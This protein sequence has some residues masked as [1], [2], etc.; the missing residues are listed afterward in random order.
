[1]VVVANIPDVTV[2][3]YL[4]RA[5][6]VAAIIGLPLAVVG[7]VLGIGA[8]DFVTPDAFALIP[9]ILADP[10]SGPLPGGVVLDAGEVATIRA[11]IEQFNAIIAR[12]AAAMGAAL[13]DIH[14][15]LDQATKRGIFVGDRRLDTD[16]LGGL[17]S[18]DGI[19]PTNTGYAIIANEFIK[20][21]NRR[22]HARIPPLDRP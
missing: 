9:A 19:H 15:L 11:A 17:F 3:P 8:G 10:A 13:V 21:L 14:R 5:E 6:E 22:F 12:E 16:F 2:I 20:A 1:N 7:P 4:T 18:L